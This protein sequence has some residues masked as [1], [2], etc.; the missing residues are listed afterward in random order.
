MSIPAMIAAW[1]AT[2]GAAFLEVEIYPADVGYLENAC[3]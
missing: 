2:L 1:L 3:E